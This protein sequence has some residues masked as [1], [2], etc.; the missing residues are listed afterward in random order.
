MG[1]FP[2]KACTKWNDE[3]S[4][5]NWRKES[6]KDGHKRPEAREVKISKTVYQFESI[7]EA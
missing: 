4:F 2:T 5:G 3:E 1:S 7:E 6:H